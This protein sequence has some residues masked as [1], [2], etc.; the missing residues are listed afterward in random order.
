MAETSSRKREGNA[1]NSEAKS[2]HW[3]HKKSLISHDWLEIGDSY[4]HKEKKIKL[5]A[6]NGKKCIVVSVYCIL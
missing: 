2:S 4:K 3:A 5:V 1:N 6:D